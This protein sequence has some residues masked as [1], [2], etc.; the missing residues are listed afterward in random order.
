RPALAIDINWNG[1]AADT[2]WSNDGNWVGGTAPGDGDVAVFDHVGGAAFGSP[3]TLTNFVDTGYPAPGGVSSLEGLWYTFNGSNY[4]HRTAID[5]GRT[6]LLTNS[7]NV[8][9]VGSGN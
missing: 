6:L 4:S 2:Q 8:A 9:T 5:T 7:L 3:G 1:A